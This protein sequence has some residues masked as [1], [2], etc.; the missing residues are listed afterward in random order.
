[1]GR[2]VVHDP[3][4]PAR[5][6]VGW[7]IHNLSN[8]PA[9]WKNP[10]RL[11]TSA[12]EL[13]AVDVPGSQV[14]PS[15]AARILVLDPG[16]TPRS[17]R[18]RCMLAEPCLDAR[19]LVGAQHELAGPQRLSVPPPGIQVE[20]PSPFLRKGGIA[21]ENPTPVLPRPDRVLAQPAPDGRAADCRH[22]ARPLG[23][24]RNVGAAQPGERHAE[25][26][27]EFTGDRFNLNDDLW[28]EKPGDDPGAEVLPS[29]AAHRERSVCA[30]D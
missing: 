11:F 16:R 21:R 7:L 29:L 19:F 13:R 22:D 18:R 10:G 23:L 24:T 8:E 30:R 27:G 5:I 17:G 3:E 26:G 4:D 1:M 20:D 14:R 2:A 9:E 15:A 12:E 25:L 28:G 6:A